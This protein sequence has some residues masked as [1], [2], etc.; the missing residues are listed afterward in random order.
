MSHHQNSKHDSTDPQ[1]RIMWGLGPC[2]YIKAINQWQQPEIVL[3]DGQEVKIY[4]P[5][6]FKY[7]PEIDS[8]IIYGHEEIQIFSSKG[9]LI[10]NIIT[11]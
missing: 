10:E 9:D 6:G 5:H 2:V 8:Y 1:N 4:E 3:L 7:V 11:R